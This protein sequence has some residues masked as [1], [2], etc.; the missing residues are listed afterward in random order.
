MAAKIIDQSPD[1]ARQT[2]GV[3][4]GA[5]SRMNVRT[6][7]R[8]SAL[9]LGGMAGGTWLGSQLGKM[10]GSGGATV[11]ASI[12]AVIGNVAS[13]TMVSQLAA[14][15]TWKAAFASLGFLWP[16]IGVLV[17]GGIVGAFKSH[18]ESIKKG[19]AEVASEASE[20]YSENLNASAEAVTY[21]KLVK[22]VDYLGRNVSL[23]DEEYQKFLDSSNALAEAFP[24]LVVRTDEL[25]NKL[26]GPDGLS[27]KVGEVTKKVDELTEASRKAADSALFKVEDKGIF[28]KS[29]GF[30]NVFDEQRDILYKANNALK[31][32]Q[33]NIY[34]VDVFGLNEEIALREST[35]ENIGKNKGTESNEY[36]KAKKE[37]E[38]LKLDRDALFEDINT[39][40]DTL[41]EYTE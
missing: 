30:S 34:G 4:V 25:G 16:A 31:Y 12:G 11:G 38:Q 37:L 22:G 24:D 26:V 36:K 7:L 18:K 41:A 13:T 20:T 8:D 9:S 35:L 28:G 19:L 32:K 1:E 21:D 33:K 10:L 3:N 17:V 5:S 27:G 39:A 6:A 23:T 15:A 40:K 14:G 2:L 29:S